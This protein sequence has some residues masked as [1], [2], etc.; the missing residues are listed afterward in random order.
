MTIY[1]HNLPSPLGQLTAAAR[2]EGLIGLWFEDQRYAPDASQWRPEAKHP[3]LRAAADWI[4]EYFA[5]GRPEYCG[6]LLLEGT[7]FRLWVWNRLL[8]ISY[9]LSATYGALRDQFVAENGRQ[10]SARAVGGAVGHNPVSLI[11]P[12][13]RV[14]GAGDNLTGYGGGLERKRALLALEREGRQT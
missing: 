10:M 5:G 8:K 2:A 14:V 13:H 12:C 4:E 3:D 7:E 1:A 11:I 9:G 6:R